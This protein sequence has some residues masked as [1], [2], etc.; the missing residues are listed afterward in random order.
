MY[1]GCQ[2]RV[3]IGQVRQEVIGRLVGPVNRKGVK[4]GG[5]L[6]NKVEAEGGEDIP[7]KVYLH[8]LHSNY[9]PHVMFVLIY[10]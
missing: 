4:R 3:R 5:I 2:G 7:T 8:Y 1:E 6:A 10:F 9:P